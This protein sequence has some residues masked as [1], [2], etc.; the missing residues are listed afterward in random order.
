MGSTRLPGKVLLPFPPDNKTMLYRVVRAARMIGGVSHVV[1]AIPNMRLDDVL[2]PHIAASGAMLSRDHETGRDV[3]GHYYRAAK[4]FRANT[5]MRVTAD[6]PM[7]DPLVCEDVL[8]LFQSGEFDLCTN[9]MP[10]TFPKGLDC[11]VFSF[12]AL[13][14]A[15]IQAQSSQYREHVTLWMKEGW[16]RENFNIGNHACSK[17]YSGQ[18]LSVDTLDDYVRVCSIL[19][20]GKRNAEMQ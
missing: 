13:E 8:K 7:L 14:F 18:N 6:C 19:G 20:R 11:E 16:N 2:V 17:D 5:I 12:E 9:V 1:V 4:H 15:H 10:R 3:L